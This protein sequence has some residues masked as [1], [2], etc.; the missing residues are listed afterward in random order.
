MLAILFWVYLVDIVLLILH[1]MDSAYWKEWELF[2]L[3]GGLTGFLLIH[4]PL[5]CLGLYG[6]VL[7][8]KG[9]SNSLIYS[10]V[11]SLAGMA[12]FAIHTWFLRKGQPEFNVPVSKIILWGTLVVSLIQAVLTIFLVFMDSYMFTTILQTL[13]ST[14]RYGALAGLHHSMFS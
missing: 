3:P 4:F 10:L 13:E 14:K 9:T 12:A 6:L 5:Y 2:H 1:E 11:I 7:L 8:S